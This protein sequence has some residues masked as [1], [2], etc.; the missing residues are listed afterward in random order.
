MASDEGPLLEANGIISSSRGMTDVGVTLLSPRGGGEERHVA[1]NRLLAGVV[2]DG[3]VHFRENAPDGPVHYRCVSS[4]L[5]TG[6][7]L[8]GFNDDGSGQNL[9]GF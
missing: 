7:L 1:R 4:A 5:L 6:S 8:T 9:D 3:P 2:P